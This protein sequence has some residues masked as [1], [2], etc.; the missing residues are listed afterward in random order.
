MT[1]DHVSCTLSSI[2]T[3]TPQKVKG[4]TYYCAVKCQ[5]VNGKPRLAMQKYLGSADDIIKAVDGY[6]KRQKPKSVR[7]LRVRMCI[8]FDSES[9]KPIAHRGHSMHGGGYRL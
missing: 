3:I 9:E 6:R 2:V 7:V 8:P 5:R 4:R 1:S